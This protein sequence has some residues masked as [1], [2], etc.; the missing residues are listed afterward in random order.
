[1]QGGCY[2]FS[3]HSIGCVSG[4]MDIS[5]YGRINPCSFSSIPPHPLVRADIYI[6][7]EP[8]HS[9]VI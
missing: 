8:R 5:G 4:I 3:V 1:V 2:G 6:T 9:R 7:L